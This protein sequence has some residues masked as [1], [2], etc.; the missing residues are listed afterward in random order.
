[1]CSKNVFGSAPTTL[2]NFEGKVLALWL[3]VNELDDSDIESDEIQPT[4]IQI[5]SVAVVVAS[6]DDVA[7]SSDMEI[8]SSDMDIASTSIQIN[9]VAVFVASSDNVAASSDKDIASSDLN[10]RSIGDSSIPKAAANIKYITKHSSSSVDYVIHFTKYHVSDNDPMTTAIDM[11][12][13]HIP[14]EFFNINTQTQFRNYG[15]I[16]KSINT[17]LSEIQPFYFF[18]CPYAACKHVS[19]SF[20]DH[21]IHGKSAHNYVCYTCGK[22]Y[23]LQHHF[24]AHIS[25]CSNETSCI[26]IN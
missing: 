18:T 17:Y 11:L 8:A 13:N 26:L 4:S 6:S 7:A 12:L 25:N 2:N 14:G 3:N 23:K 16:Y 20:A 19:R 9:S 15:P 24:N 1:M 10:S 5:N 22:C 21:L